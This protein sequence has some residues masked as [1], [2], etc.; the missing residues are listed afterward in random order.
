MKKFLLSV[1]SFLGMSGVAL[2]ASPAPSS[3]IPVA[4][5]TLLAD[6]VSY[7]PVLF[8]DLFPLIALVVGVPVGF[9]II[10]KAIGL[11]RRNTT[12]GGGGR[13]T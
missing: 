9:W 6:A 12:S 3:I 1:A 7:V 2:A 13:R 10:T 4:S 8:T 5:S 11:V